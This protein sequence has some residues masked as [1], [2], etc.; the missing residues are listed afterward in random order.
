MKN[1]IATLLLIF[2]SVIIYAQK[3]TDVLFKVNHISVTVSEFKKVYERNID[4]LVDDAQKE[5]E[6]YLELYINYKLKVLQ[7]YQ[8][9]LDTTKV[10]QRDIKTY[11]SQLAA[12]YLQDTVYLGKLVKDAYFRTSN[13]IR[14]SHILVGFSANA[15][16]KDT[17]IAYQKII[18][19]RNEIIAGRPFAEV[20]KRIS[21]D[22][23]VKSNGGDLGYFSAF[24]MVYPFENAA[25]NTK[26][27]VISM[28]FKTKF[29]YHIVKVV[30]VKKSEGAIE[31]AHILIVDKTTKGRNEIDSIY[32]LIQR[33]GDF[34]KLA[35]KFSK[36]PG[37]VGKGG[38]LSK[39]RRGALDPEFE[40]IAYSLTKNNRLSTPFR[41]RFGWHIIKLIKRYPIKSFAQLK[42]QLTRRV[43]SSGRAKLSDLAVLKRLKN[44]YKIIV[45]EQFKEVFAKS[46][47]NALPTD[48]LENVLFTINDKK[49]MQF[50]YRDYA[51]T[52]KRT[53]TITLF[54]AFLNEEILTYFKENLIHTEPEYAAS[55][56][57]Y[58]DGVL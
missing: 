19:A 46:N 34:G 5:L 26:V 4:L 53:S 14:A 7:A 12:P 27:G 2:F 33:G 20:A 17:L 16:P 35:N 30:D 57:E 9:K 6:N 49:I 28:P 13:E 23:S 47:I 31:V 25:Y 3:D 38:K 42:E 18:K 32:N 56:K 40:N 58:Q 41:T 39:F 22:R 48:S 29:G 51:K 45:N 10:Y 37:T 43:K 44:E 55:L 36:D 52:K 24:R 11:K 50:Q 8:L 21:S 1:K 54:N 15:K